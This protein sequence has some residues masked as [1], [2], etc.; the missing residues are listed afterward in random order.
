MSKPGKS[1]SKG[2]Q[3]PDDRDKSGQTPAQEAGM[4]DGLNISGPED[5]NASAGSTKEDWI[6]S[7][8]KRVYDE[9]LKEPVPDDMMALLNQLD[10]LPPK[11]ARRDS[12]EEA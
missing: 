3:A 12:D 4:M 6:G 9:A 11:K 7:Q 1:A 2:S 8:L 5:D 10:A